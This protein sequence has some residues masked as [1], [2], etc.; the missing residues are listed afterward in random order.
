MR[1]VIKMTPSHEEC[2]GQ[3]RR[4]ES[5]RRQRSSTQSKSPQPQRQRHTKSQSSS[6]PKSTERYRHSHSHTRSRPRPKSRLS[7]PLSTSTIEGCAGFS[8]SSSS[9]STGRENFRIIRRGRSHSGKMT[10]GGKQCSTVVVELDDTER[11]KEPRSKRRLY[12]PKYDPKSEFYMVTEVGEREPSRER[13]GTR[14]AGHK[15]KN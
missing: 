8:S 3:S 10:H 2:R 15:H 9:I 4:P 6:R 13:R 1:V 14:I 5:T 7:S 11:S 12:A